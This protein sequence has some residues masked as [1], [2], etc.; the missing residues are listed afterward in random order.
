[1]EGHLEEGPTSGVSSQSCTSLVTLITLTC[2]D[3]VFLSANGQ[4]LA[5]QDWVVLIVLVSQGCHKLGGFK[6]DSYSLTIL[7]AKSPPSRCW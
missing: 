3:L 1:M 4:H 5:G 2:K 6:T 7:E